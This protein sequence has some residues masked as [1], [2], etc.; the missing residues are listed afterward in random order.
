MLWAKRSIRLSPMKF[1]KRVFV[2]QTYKIDTCYRP[3]LVRFTGYGPWAWI[4]RM[5]CRRNALDY[6]SRAQPIS[7]ALDGETTGANK[8]PA[9]FNKQKP[10]VEIVL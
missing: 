9:L 6:M 3:I 1:F 7:V 4:A 2:T 8:Q 10:K 5:L